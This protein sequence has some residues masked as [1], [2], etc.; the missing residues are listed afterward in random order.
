ML[1]PVIV[2][3]KKSGYEMLAGHNRLNATKIA[4]LT[5]IP[6]IVKTELSEEEAYVYVIETNLIQR[7]FSELLPSE[8]AVVLSERYEKIS[9]QGRRNDIRREIEI[10]S[11]KKP[12]ETCGHDVHKK[13]RDSIGEEYGMTGRN[14]ARY[15]R[16]NQLIEPLKA[17]LDAGEISLVTAVDL[18]YL[19]EKEQEMVSEQAKWSGIKIS[20]KSVKELRER[21]GSLADKDVADVMNPKTNTSKTV[22][23]KI[24]VET[25]E[26]YFAG[27]TAKERSDVVVMALDA[28]FSGKEPAYV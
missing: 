3:K 21:S 23:I 15:M 14:I 12:T 20:Q 6:A 10:M 11:G 24:P 13:S 1:N 17:M 2:W 8:R 27:K 22:S 7:S 28:W 16:V 26:K 4:G 19:D 9:C 18:S 25:G 5:E